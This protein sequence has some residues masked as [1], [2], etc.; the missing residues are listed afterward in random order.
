M[1]GAPIPD[2]LGAARAAYDV[3]GFQMVRRKAAENGHLTDELD[4]QLTPIGEALSHRPV[5][6]TPDTRP[7]CGDCGHVHAGE[8]LGG[9]CIGCPCEQ[10]G[11][12]R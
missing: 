11:G 10:R 9:I 1:S 5:G 6:D 12:A 2:Y 3:A 8:R 7:R 4:A